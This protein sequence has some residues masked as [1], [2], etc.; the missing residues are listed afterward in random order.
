MFCTLLTA[1]KAM[2]FV[3]YTGTVSGGGEG[4]PLKTHHIGFN[5]LK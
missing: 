4:V 5:N 1:E 3:N 2:A